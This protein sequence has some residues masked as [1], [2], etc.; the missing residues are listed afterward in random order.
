[1]FI[2]D[3]GKSDEYYAKVFVD[4]IEK[5]ITVLKLPGLGN[6]GVRIEQVD[7]IVDSTSLKNNPVLLAREDLLDILLSRI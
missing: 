2:K 7:K 1:M 5:L 4:Y 6:F 3:T